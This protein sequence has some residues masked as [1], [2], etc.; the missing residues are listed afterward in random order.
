MTSTSGFNERYEKPS[1]ALTFGHDNQRTKRVQQNHKILKQVIKTIE[2]CGKQNII[3]KRH[4]ENVAS[5]E[6]NCG[7]FLVILELLA[8]TSDGL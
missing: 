7:N 1:S 6:S 2:L 4:H 8:Q 5:I 3:F